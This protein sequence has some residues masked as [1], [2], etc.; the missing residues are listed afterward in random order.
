MFGWE[1]PPHI[2]G[3]L[4][5]ACF[6]LTKGLASFDDIERKGMDFA[7]KVIT[8]SDFT[9][10]IVIE[11]YHINPLKVITIYNALEPSDICGS[12]TVC[13]L[14]TENKIVTFLGRITW[15]KGPKYFIKAAFKVLQKMDNDR[16]VMSGSGDLMEEMVR[17]YKS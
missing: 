9:R 8:V 17:C 7:D 3:G 2:S 14:G 1:F 5:T 15:Q 13:K 4:G 16:F 10:N 11:K 12:N 6:G